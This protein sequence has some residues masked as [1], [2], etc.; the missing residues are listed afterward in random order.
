MDSILKEISE[1]F[2]VTKFGSLLE[3]IKDLRSSEEQ[4]TALNSILS[5]IN[6]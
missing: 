2:E 6:E 5:G 4:K 3:D 1:E